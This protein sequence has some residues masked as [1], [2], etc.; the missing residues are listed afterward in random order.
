MR[1]HLHVVRLAACIAASSALLCTS[2]LAA[3]GASTPPS[4]TATSTPPPA[5]SGSGLFEIAS[6]TVTGAGP[7]ATV[8]S[9][10][11]TGGAFFEAGSRGAGTNNWNIAFTC[12]GR[13]YY[14]I[15]GKL[16]RN[17]VQIGSGTSQGFKATE[18]IDE[19]IPCSSPSACAGSYLLT[20]SGDLTLPA[21]GVW[22]GASGACSI[23]SVSDALVC[24][25]T[26]NYTV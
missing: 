4:I 11:F 2:N 15:Q 12:N 21:G 22:I 3:T 7:Q 18:Q 26:Q 10:T 8:Y 25:G 6:P 9:C 5:F 24:S 13:V 17:G 1:I 14:E 16:T 20:G 19:T 23:S